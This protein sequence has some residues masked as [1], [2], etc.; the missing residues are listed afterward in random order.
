M[1]PYS[2]TRSLPKEYS[3]GGA[4]SEELLEDLQPFGV[5]G[6]S[7]EY[8]LLAFCFRQLEDDGRLG[9]SK[10][11]WRIDVVKFLSFEKQDRDCSWM[12]ARTGRFTALGFLRLLAISKQLVLCYGLSEYGKEER[13]PFLR[14]AIPLINF[15]KAEL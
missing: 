14:S 4:D 6:I 13:P 1:R 3:R 8:M 2:S 15:Q 5:G 9:T 12:L 11:D 10:S 7:D